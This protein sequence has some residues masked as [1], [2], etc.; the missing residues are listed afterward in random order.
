MS[1]LINVQ[2]V[3]AERGNTSQHGF[4]KNSM[5]VFLDQIYHLITYLW[6]PRWRYMNH[7]MLF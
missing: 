3:F 4:K 1:N 6:V 7:D 5:Y 2:I